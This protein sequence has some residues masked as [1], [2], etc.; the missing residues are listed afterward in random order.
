MRRM[1]VIYTVKQNDEHPRSYGSPILPLTPSPDPD[2]KYAKKYSFI[3]A[4]IGNSTSTKTKSHHVSILKSKTDCNCDSV[5]NNTHA[6]FFVSDMKACYG[7]LNASFDS[8]TSPSENSITVLLGNS[9][10]N[11]GINN[12]E[13]YSLNS[14]K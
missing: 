14:S 13:F 8:V 7:E 12:G 4:N 11:Q 1:S 5:Y 3:H 2:S 6:L 9:T 10:Q